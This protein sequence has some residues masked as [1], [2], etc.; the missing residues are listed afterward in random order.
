MRIIRLGGWWRPNYSAEEAHF[1][2]W[3]HCLTIGPV[4]IFWR[5]MTETELAADAARFEVRQ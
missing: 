1:W 4:V 2:G 3:R 5:P